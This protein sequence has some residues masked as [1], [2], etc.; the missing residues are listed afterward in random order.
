MELEIEHDES[1]HRFVAEL[2]G[3]Q[4]YVEYRK[5]PAGK[6]DLFRTYVPKPLGGRGIAAKLVPRMIDWLDSLSHD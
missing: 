4:A 1:V 2:N 5:E 6:I 3:M